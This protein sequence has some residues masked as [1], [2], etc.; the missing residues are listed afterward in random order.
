MS[1][2]SFL[3]KFIKIYVNLR[4]CQTNKILSMANVRNV[5]KRRGFMPLPNNNQGGLMKI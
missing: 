5:L 3:I 2:F 1:P 4:N